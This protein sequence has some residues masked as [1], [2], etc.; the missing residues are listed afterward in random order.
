MPPQPTEPLTPGWP[1]FAVAR[2]RALR[3]RC[4]ARPNPGGASCRQ[5][6]WRGWRPQC[7]NPLI[8]DVFS[9][10]LLA[11]ARKTVRASF[12]GWKRRFGAVHFGTGTCKQGGVKWTEQCAKEVKEKAGRAF[13]PLCSQLSSAQVRAPKKMDDSLPKRYEHES[14][15]IKSIFL[16]TLHGQKRGICNDKTW[17]RTLVKPPSSCAFQPPKEYQEGWTI[18]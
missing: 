18:R 12:K 7:I 10:V 4:S 17:P 3:Q 5:N 15:W 11:H 16:A 9:Q 2:L 1:A 6:E 8:T 14:V 13:T